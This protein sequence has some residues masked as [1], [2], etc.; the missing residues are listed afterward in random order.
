MRDSDVGVRDREEPLKHVVGRIGWAGATILGVLA[1]PAISG[2]SPIAPRETRASICAA[3]HTAV[4]HAARRHHPSSRPPRH[5]HVHASLQAAASGESRAPFSA[6]RP[7]PAHEG[8]RHA[9]LPHVFKMGQHRTANSGSRDAA[10]AFGESGLIAGSTTP[11]DA[12]QNQGVNQ[13]E[14][15]LKAGRGPPRASPLAPLP[16][17]SAARSIGSHSPARPR[18]DIPSIPSTSSPVA[19]PRGAFA[20]AADPAPGDFRF[21]RF[22]SAWPCGHAC[23][24]RPEGPAAQ[25]FRLSTG[26]LS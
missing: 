4:H 14:Q 3:M 23:A 19:P 26:G 21:V 10:L 17:P 8:H 12:R 1:L 6:P 2:A 9:T 24:V 15:T 18:F 5:R 11:L 7:A 20:S 22:K 16:A 25:F 13:P